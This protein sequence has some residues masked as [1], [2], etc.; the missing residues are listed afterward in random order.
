MSVDAGADRFIAQTFALA[1]RIAPDGHLEAAVG[2][3]ALVLAIDDSDERARPEN[4]P[5]F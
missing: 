3:N 5:R 2:P 4:T 1:E